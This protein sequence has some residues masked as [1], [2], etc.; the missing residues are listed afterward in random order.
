[1]GISPTTHRKIAPALGW[2]GNYLSPSQENV[3]MTACSQLVVECECQY[4]LS[5]SQHFFPA[6]Q[7]A[8]DRILTSPTVLFC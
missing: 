1:M 8:T 2:T 3:K 5:P 4:D 7:P 6:I